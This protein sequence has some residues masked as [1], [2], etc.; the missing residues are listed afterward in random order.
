VPGAPFF[1]EPGHDHTVR[2]S[3]VTVSPEK[4]EQGVALFAQVL[5][6]ALAHA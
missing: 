4:I 3:F 5:K 6:Q 1:L 2:L